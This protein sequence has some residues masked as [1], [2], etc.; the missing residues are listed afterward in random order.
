MWIPRDLQLASRHLLDSDERRSEFLGSSGA[1]KPLGRAV[2][3]WTSARRYREATDAY[4]HKGPYVPILLEACQEGEYAYEYRHGATSYRAFTYSLVNIFR[5]AARSGKGLNWEV[6]MRRVAKLLKE[7]EYQQTPRCW[8]ARGRSK[9][10]GCRGKG[11]PASSRGF[12][13]T[14]PYH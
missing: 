9:R 4:G 13:L 2:P 11:R 10:P 5:Q 8:S 7:L 1:I 6:L 14:S 12:S 3:T